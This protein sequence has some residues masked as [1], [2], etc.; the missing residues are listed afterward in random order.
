MII[1]FESGRLGNQLFQYVAIR[2]TFKSPEKIILVG[3]DSLKN[4]FDGV[5]AFFINKNSWPMRILIKIIRKL[6]RKGWLDRFFNVAYESISE[7]RIIIRKNVSWLNLLYIKEAY[8]QS[9][10]FLDDKVI[11]QLSFKNFAT[12]EILAGYGLNLSDPNLFFIHVRRGDYLFWPSLDYP[13][14]LDDTWYL[15]QI[16]EITKIKAKPRFLFFTDD[17]DYVKNNFLQKIDNADI[18]HVSEAVDLAAM[19]F[20]GG[21]GILSASSY[22]WWA[23]RLSFIA[24]QDAQFIAPKYWVGHIKKTWHPPR[25]ETSFLRYV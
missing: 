20:C 11:N 1:F 4:S 19:S 14:A 7:S 12:K 5:D 18:F 15:K 23:A 10:R 3:F 25:I 16:D 21:G 24:R 2:S 8:F 22:A 17:P 6:E 9:E 13:A